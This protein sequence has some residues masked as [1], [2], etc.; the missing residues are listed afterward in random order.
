M[1]GI[2]PS[3]GDQVR[4][5]NAR[6]QMTTSIQVRDRV[7]EGQAVFPE[8]FD[9]DVRRLLS[10]SPDPQTGVPY[11]KTTRVKVEKV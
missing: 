7:P 1:P 11:F 10:M 9:Q 2:S 5:S 3:E 6:G 8:H 4:L